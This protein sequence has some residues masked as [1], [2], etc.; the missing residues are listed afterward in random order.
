MYEMYEMSLQEVINHDRMLL[1]K[2]KAIPPDELWTLFKLHMNDTSERATNF[3]TEWGTKLQ[4]AGTDKSINILACLSAHKDLNFNSQHFKSMVDM[5][6]LK[7]SLGSYQGFKALTITPPG[8]LLGKLAEY[9][10][11]L[12]S[13]GKTEF[14]TKWRTLNIDQNDMTHNAKICLE[15]LELNALE[16]PAKKC[17]QKM[18]LRMAGET[19]PP[20]DTRE[21]VNERVTKKLQAAMAKHVSAISKVSKVQ[22]K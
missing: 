2:L 8:V 21:R 15:A 17:V 16:F 14:L 3:E 12:D 1:E 10:G 6:D 19:E 9:M 11:L 13:P 7:S 18:L 4:Q 22:K 20:L 5:F